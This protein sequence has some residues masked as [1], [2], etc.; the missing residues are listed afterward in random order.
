MPTVSFLAIAKMRQPTFLYSPETNNCFS[1][2]S[3]LKD[4]ARV[5][6]LLTIFRKGAMKSVPMPHPGSVHRC[7]ESVSTH[8]NY[9][10]WGQ[11]VGRCRHRYE[12][13]L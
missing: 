11:A 1:M 6:G 3:A 7:T 10:Q 12:R 5:N 2:K 9:F 13:P 4:V 8:S